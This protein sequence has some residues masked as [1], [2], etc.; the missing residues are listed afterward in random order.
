MLRR[1][2]LPYAFLLNRDLGLGS[3]FPVLTIA[4]A[5]IIVELLHYAS[6]KNGP[7]RRRRR[8]I[9]YPT[10]PATRGSG[11]SFKNGFV[12]GD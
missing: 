9:H 10:L 5:S 4:A 7:E 8:I 2:H 6:N 11:I 1:S 12:R 3:R